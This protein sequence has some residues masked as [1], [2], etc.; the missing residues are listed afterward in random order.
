MMALVM[1][2]FYFFL[3]LGA[4]LISRLLYR[5]TNLLLFTPFLIAPL[6]LALLLMGTGVEYET[7]NKGAA[8]LTKLLQPAT[9]AFAIPL[10][11]YSGLL[12]KH[13][14][15]M[16]VG[17]VCGILISL[18]TTLLLTR[19]AQMDAS[20]VKSLLPHTVTTPLAMILSETLKGD[21][22]ISVLFTIMTGICGMVLGPLVIRIFK[23]K[24]EVS[25]GLLLGVGAHAA[26]TAKA[27]ELGEQEGAIAS[28]VT[29]VTALLTIVVAPT[30]LHLIGFT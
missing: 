30:L 19:L 8:Y 17:I 13:W 5:K 3:T 27:F 22:Q 7:Y 21:P 11:R 1:G 20:T 28:V 6:A 23:I 10:Y 4:Y 24:H 9:V 25:K 15:P 2:L 12:R 26:G 29:I 18:G 14:K 16:V